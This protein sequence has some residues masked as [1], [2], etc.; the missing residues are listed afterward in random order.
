MHTS[1]TDPVLIL[2]IFN[3]IVYGYVSAPAPSNNKSSGGLFGSTPVPATAAPSPAPASTVN[4][5]QIQPI[6][7]IPAYHTTFPRLQTR[8]TVLDHV[9]RVAGS[10]RELIHILSNEEGKLLSDTK[11]ILKKPTEDGTLR[12]A[13][14]QCRDGASNATG[15][16]TPVG[17]GGLFGT[18]GGV[19]GQR[20]NHQGQQQQQQPQTPRVTVT[21]SD[22]P[23]SITQSIARD[24]LRLSDELHLSVSDAVALFAEANALVTR[25]EDGRTE[26]DDDFVKVLIRNGKMGLDDEKLDGE[27]KNKTPQRRE[28][29]VSRII[30]T[31][32]H[33]FFHERAALLST[34]LD[35]VRYRIQAAEE[36][37]DTSPIIAATD[38]LL[39]S[40]LVTNLIASIRELNDMTRELRRDLKN[41][42]AENKRMKSMGGANNN[43]SM[44]G[45]SMGGF[46]A[47]TAP[48]TAQTGQNLDMKCALLGFTQMQR[49]LAAECLFY[50]AYHTQLTADEVCSLID[51]IKDLTNGNESTHDEG[52]P[53][54]DPLVKDVPRPYEEDSMAKFD[55]QQ[56][57]HYGAWNKSLSMK[58]KSEKVWEEELISMLWARGQPQLLQCISTL[59]MSFTCALD[60]RHTLMNRQNHGPNLFGKGNALL[61]PM[62]GDM[63]PSSLGDLQSVHSRLDPESQDAEKEWKRRDIWG[64]LLVPYAL[65]LRNAA[66]P[67]LLSPRGSGGSRPSPTRSPPVQ[68]GQVNMQ[69]TCTKCLMVASQLKSLTF[70]RMSL[71]PSFGTSSLSKL[72]KHGVDSSI[73]D[74]YVT[75]FAD[76]TSQ[77]IDALC[78]T[79]NLPITRR[80]WFD[81]EYQLAQA[82][83]AEKEQRRQF[84]VWA[85]QTIKDDASG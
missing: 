20:Q 30:Q 14:I 75:V 12:N 29:G 60:A 78:A 69:A 54:L 17:G 16:P 6:A 8:N 26:F 62:S 39:Q 15:G 84:G 44:G 7:N 68:I 38:K 24:V 71:V 41:A 65:L 32:R 58:A 82:E 63:V 28:G 50:L 11:S 61:P 46:G 74:F 42:M 19:F 66:G 37:N 57:Q 25:H 10:G 27:A 21:L 56:Q 35:L 83:W 31:A 18:S 77:F 40:G 55:W 13:L 9:Q 5:S 80:E 79:G 73:V 51:L 76:F 85:G 3:I 49:Q 22:K 2:H 36:S 1:S 72:E 70:A 33:L 23:A 53:L 48:S 45:N 4:T 67:Q 43:A 47:N 64:L 34:I 52:L 81:D 59:I